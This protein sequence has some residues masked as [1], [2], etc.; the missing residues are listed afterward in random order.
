MMTQVAATRAKYADYQAVVAESSL[1][2]SDAM[3]DYV[4][5]SGVFAGELLYYLGTHPD[6]CRALADDENEARVQ[7]AMR[8]IEQSLR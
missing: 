1:P 5:R 6:E 2:V 3:V 7:E 4:H 8:R